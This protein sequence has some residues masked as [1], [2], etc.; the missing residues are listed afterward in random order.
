[1]LACE[2]FTWFGTTGSKSR[3]N[4][5]ALLRA[6]HSDYVINDAALAY[7]H[8]RALAGPIVARLAQPIRLIWFT[9]GLLF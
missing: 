6:R 7:M 2:R 3:L 8:G 5:L 1:M 4:F 9:D